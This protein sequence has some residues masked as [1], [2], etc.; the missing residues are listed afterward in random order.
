VMQLMAGVNFAVGYLKLSPAEADGLRAA[1]RKIEEE[2]QEADNEQA[3]MDHFN[4]LA[5]DDPEWRAKRGAV[6][7]QI[8]RE[9][10]RL[11]ERI[12]GEVKARLLL[13]TMRKSEGGDD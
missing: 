3:A 5:K 2:T 1:A 11:N 10:R 13:D 9:K 8:E 4:Q 6:G 12:D 7:D